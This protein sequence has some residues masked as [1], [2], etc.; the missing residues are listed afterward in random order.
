MKMLNLEY[1]KD[2]W[3]WFEPDSV[4][5]IQFFITN[6]CNKRCIGCFYGNQLDS[7]TDMTLDEYRIK[8][9]PYLDAVKKVVLIGGE[10]TISPYIRD[11]IQYNQAHGL[12]TTVYTNGY[13][14]SKLKDIDLSGVTVRIGVLGLY[15]SEKPL[16]EITPPSIPVFIVYMLRKNNVDNLME[17]VLYAE[18]HYLCSDFMLS[19][20]RDIEVTKSFWKD[21]DETF[22]N[23]EYV[24]IVQDF[25]KKYDG[26]MN[27][28]ISRRGLINGDKHVKKCRFLNVFPQTDNAIICPLDISLEIYCDIHQYKFGDRICN[29]NTECCLQKVV[30]KNKSIEK[31]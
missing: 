15:E 28:H 2:Q 13:D 6:R 8:L 24:E 27:I 3:E 19:S 22:S 31:N 26:K 14:L 17:T 4:N 12:L 5:T 23:E 11:M 25:I 7:H 30:L 18:K 9:S 20:I 16:A 29:K 1:D 21:T 10:P